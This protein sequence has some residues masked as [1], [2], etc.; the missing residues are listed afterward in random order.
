MFYWKNIEKIIVFGKGC[1]TGSDECTDSES[2]AF[3]L[4]TLEPGERLQMFPKI[5][6]DLKYENVSL[7]YEFILFPNWFKF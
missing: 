5:N 7:M 6:P 2:V 4:D 1:D 3:L